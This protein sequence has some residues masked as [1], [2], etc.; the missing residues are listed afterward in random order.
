[1]LSASTEH[2]I[3]THIGPIAETL[4]QLQQL[5]TAFGLE[6]SQTASPAVVFETVADSNNTNTVAGYRELGAGPARQH[7][8][9]AMLQIDY[10]MEDKVNQS[11]KCNGAIGVP[12]RL[13]SDAL[14]INR[15]K[16][17]FKDAMKSVAGKRV[18][19]AVK[20]RHGQTV[21]KMKE[22]S[23]VILRRIQSSSINVLAAYREIPLLEETPSS[24]RMML[25]HTRSVPRKT[26]AELL[27]LLAGRDD[28]LATADRERLEILDPNE[29]LVSPKER[30]PRMRAHV[31]YR[32]LDESGRPE[33]Q[34]VMAELPILYP[35]RK[36]T[37]PPDV[38]KPGARQGSRK[39]P[40]SHIE[41]EEY[42]K[43]HHFRRMKP[44]HREYAVPEKT[45]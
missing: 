42:V 38:T 26:V 20:D 32:R 5:L 39:H 29:Y 11:I 36:G 23:N 3:A 22:L 17:E 12:K 30:Y 28:T 16:S 21:V 25:T 7:A 10:A 31:F 41:C 43:T 4:R 6:L 2:L 33:R 37:R 1:M 19:V 9:E 45:Q 18:R 13:I 44:G 8:I 27:N 15:A 35:I 40:V 14:I 34:I 24:I